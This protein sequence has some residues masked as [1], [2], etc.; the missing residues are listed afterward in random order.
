MASAGTTQAVAAGAIGNVLEWYD[1]AIYGYFAAAI[2]RTYFP[3]Q[4]PVAQVLSAFGVFAVGFLMRPVGGALIGRIADRFGRRAALT[5]SVMS[6]AIPTFLVGALPGYQTLGV[7][8]PILLVLLRMAQGLSIGGEY[9]TSIVFMVEHAPPG[10]RGVVGALAGCSTSSGIL[11][12][13]ATATAINT[14]M[15]P[16]ALAEWG[17][18]IPFLLGLVV[19]LVGF[20]LRRNVPEAPKKTIAAHPSLI[21]TVRDHGALVAWLAGLSVFKAVGF[22]LMFLYIVSWLQFADGIAPSHAL[23]I[24]TVSMV[25]LILVTFGMGW[26]SDRIGRKPLLLAATVIAFIGGL[27]LFWLMHH[28]DPVLILVGQMGFVL[29]VGMSLGVQPATMVEVTPLAGRCTVV[30]L[31]YNVTYGIIGGFTPLIATWLVQRTEND[32]SPALMIVGAAAISFLVL[33]RYKETYKAK[34]DIA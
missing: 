6:M 7:M 10:R 18:R 22:Y 28:S 24:N 25:A 19:G 30:A 14:M 1:F 32:L 5:F 16:E 34:L 4:N 8:A 26:L 13:A 3:D 23:A 2:G 29:A 17:W 11:L 20:V 27:P 31:G 21:E 12:G 15:S 9:T 33:L